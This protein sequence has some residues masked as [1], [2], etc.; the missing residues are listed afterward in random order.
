MSGGNADGD[1]EGLC[2]VW[3]W[4][5]GDGYEGCG[6]FFGRRGRER[7]GKGIAETRNVVWENQ[8]SLAKLRPKYVV[9]AG[10]SEATPGL[11][12]GLA[13]VPSRSNFQKFTASNLRVALAK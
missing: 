12:D 2:G 1:G 5:V 8:L 9:A 4:G 10:P 7:G 3:M 11:R 6:I 13:Q